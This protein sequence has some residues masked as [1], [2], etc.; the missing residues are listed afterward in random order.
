MRRL[1]S[2][3]VVLLLAICVSASAAW[4]GT[5]LYAMDDATNSLYTID[6]NTYALTFVGNTGVSGDFGDLAFNTDNNT[7]YWVPGRGNNSLYTINLGTGAAT[8]VGS[9]GVNDLFAL[10]YD[11]ATHS[12][13]GDATN[14]NFYSINTSTGA[15]T[16]LGNN[17]VYPGGLTYRADINQLVLVQAGGNGSF[18]SV[19]PATGQVTLLGSPG[20]L[21]DNGVAWDP[22][23]GVFFVDDWNGNLYTVDP[24]TYQSTIVSGL[25]GDPFDGIIFPGGGGGGG[26]PE[27]ASLLLFGTALAGLGSKLRWKK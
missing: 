6:P 25:N 1:V 26:V 24:N 15:A 22:E 2:L 12:L 9:H 5:L 3:A 10:A 17:G 23:R 7:A 21:N 16:L 27:P 18:Y 13:Y 19:D 14:G 8:L 4:A 20:F 11:S